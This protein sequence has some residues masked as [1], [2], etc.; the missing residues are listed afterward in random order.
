MRA[1]AENTVIQLEITNACWLACQG[2]T[3]HVGHHRKPFFMGLDFA[4][5]AIRA[6]IDSPCRIGLM[7]GEPTLHPRFPE[8]LALWRD[9]VPAA[10]RE[11]WTAGFKWGE[12][13]R[14]IKDTFRP[15]LIHYNDHVAYDGMH[16]P[17]LIALDEVIDDPG[18]KKQLLDNC[19]YQT[20]WSASITPK[21]AFFCEIAASLDW[22]FDGPG[23]WPVEPGWWKRTVADYTDQIERYCGNCSGAIPMAAFSDGR[24][25]R[26]GPTIDHVTPGILAKLVKAGSPKAQKGHYK[27]FDRKITR[28]DIAAYEGQNPRAY[29]TFEAHK[30]EDV[31]KHLT[32]EK[33]C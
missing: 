32:G 13:E 21:G 30:P 27:V 28:E 24:G 19:P 6:T 7:G 29:R 11:F 20:H 15:D 23:G 17:L 8:L 9:L 16:K 14:D 1:I 10:R 31:E 2:C 33:T 22:L 12:Y 5:R 3:R 18:L 4:E 26:D 25:G